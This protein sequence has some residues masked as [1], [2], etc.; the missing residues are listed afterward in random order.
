MA[1]TLAVCGAFDAAGMTWINMTEWR[2][3]RLRTGGAWPLTQIIA[4]GTA[5][6]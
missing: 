6:I 1:R 2:S 5:A 3:D 4:G